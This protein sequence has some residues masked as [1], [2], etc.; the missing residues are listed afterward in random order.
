VYKV[1]PKA[2]AMIKKHKEDCDKIREERKKDKKRGKNIKDIEDKYESPEDR[3]IK[4]RRT[5]SLFW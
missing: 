3:N 5:D 1:S 2:I 4:G